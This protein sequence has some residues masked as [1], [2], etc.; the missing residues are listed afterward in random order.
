MKIDEFSTLNE[1]FSLAIERYRRLIALKLAKPKAEDEEPPKHAYHET[2][3][4]ELGELAERFSGALAELGL[5]KGDRVAILAKPCLEWQVALWGALRLGAIVVP[6][7]TE[8]TPPEIERILRESGAKALIAGGGGRLLDKDKIERAV[9]GHEIKIAHS[10]RMGEPFWKLLEGK[11]PAP[12]PPAEVHPE[13]LALIVYT[14][15]T[16]GNAKG[17]MLSHHNL[18]SNVRAFLPRLDVSSKD[19]I[20]SII[21]WHH[22]FGFTATILAPLA[23]GATL[24]YTDDY[25]SIP[26]MMLQNG[27]TILV[28]VPKLFHAMFQRIE[29]RLAHGGLK[30]RL[31]YRFFP[32]LAGR[33]LRKRLTGK[34]FRFIISGGAPLDPRVIRGFRRLG[35]GVIE[36][37]GLSETSPVLTFSTPF[38]R[39]AGS[40]GPPVPG[41]EIK[42]L[43]PDDQGI[44]EVLVRGPNVMQGYYKNP[45]RTEEVLDPE[46]WFH[47]GDLG[48]LDRDGWLYLHGRRKNVIV[49][50]SGKNVY[51]EE[52]EFELGKIPYIQEVL[53][54]RGFRGGKEVVQALIY[55]DWERLGERGLS[56]ADVE[57]VKELIWEEIALRQ[58]ELAPYKR[59]KSREDLIILSEP[60]EKTSKQ[61][62]K[63]YLYQEQEK[64]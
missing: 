54:K 26:R 17:V 42:I 34:A 64:G 6:I 5:E 40:V 59:I 20:L 33:V 14:S 35:L 31:V 18:A 45:T 52:V 36:G 43:D 19:V 8:L 58:R 24:I 2:S 41:V 55:P 27:V 30:A 37:Y 22:I 50:E 1:L 13:D 16:T 62:I 61:D 39:K 48:R 60:F 51:P 28:G 29:E 23:V 9:A 44:G 12:P 10:I 57:G 3:Y 46:G 53:V 47:T 49:L 25:K 21:P 11:E 56:E 7:D 38:N 15:G 63:R 32:R 4:G